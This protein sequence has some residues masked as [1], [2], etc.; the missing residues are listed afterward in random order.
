M[1]YFALRRQTLAR[2]LKS[3]DK[4]LDAALVT[5]PV[6]VTYLTGFTGEASF[7]IVT[8][9]TSVLVSD[10]RFSEQIREECPDIGKVGE[11][12]L[13]VRP[14]NRTV[15]DATAD[16][17]GKMGLKN[18]S[19]EGSR[20]SVSELQTLQ[21]YATKTTFVPQTDVVESQR[22]IKDMG[23]IERIREAVAVA[24]RAFR[25]FIATLAPTDTE[26]EM[27]DALDGYLRR[28]GARG[29][30]F[31]TI[32]GAGERAALPHAPPTGRRLEECSKLLVDWGA[33]LVYKSDITRVIRSPFVTTP[34]RK[35]KQE[36]TA[37]SLEEVYEIVLAA[38]NAALAQIR[39]GVKCSDV[40][41]AARS[42]IAN[43]KL[44]SDSK[45]KLGDCFHHGLG[46]GIGLEIHEAPRVRANSDDVLE[47]GMVITVEPG[48]Y[49][50]GWGGVR[51]ED[52]VLVT[53]DGCTLLTTLPRDLPT[54]V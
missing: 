43:S 37:Y 46:H 29:A 21:S 2:T 12:E 17:I 42:L 5:S 33:D 30:A 22:A 11:L 53:R 24:E 35:N 20:I 16:V 28:S 3:S 19:V 25:M 6:N 45:L 50:P 8:P 38:Q 15:E 10:Y 27:V 7:L 49:I 39:P 4:G 52:D 47:A 40:D 54:R 9:K 1:N 44:K 36:R 41:G 13:H 26:K 34:T 32:V 23:E 48:I 51:I 18:V 31:S 14:H